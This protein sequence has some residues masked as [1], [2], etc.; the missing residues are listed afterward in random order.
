MP[1]F[2]LSFNSSDKYVNNK[3]SS[4]QLSHQYSKNLGLSNAFYLKAKDLTASCKPIEPAAS[5]SEPCGLFIRTNCPH[6]SVECKYQII[7]SYVNSA[8]QRI[9]FGKPVN[10]IMLESTFQYYYAVLKKGKTDR[11]I[12][13]VLSSDKKNTDLYVSLQENP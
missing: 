2:D 10:Q 4:Y 3:N 11:D 5:L 9:T 12:V 1:I 7:V 8:P 13:I 6:E